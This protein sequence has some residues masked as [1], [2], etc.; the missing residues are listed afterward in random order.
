MRILN[1]A[2][3]R[4]KGPAAEVSVLSLGSQRALPTTPAQSQPH[5]LPRMQAR[6][7][8]AHIHPAVPQLFHPKQKGFGC[9]RP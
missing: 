5:P 6:H 9:T 7:S 1:P 8:C 2:L 4:E 3:S